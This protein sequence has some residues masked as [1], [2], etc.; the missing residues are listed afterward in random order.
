M[1]TKIDKNQITFI[2]S[3]F[4][5]NEAGQ[6]FPSVTTILEAYPKPYQLLQWL[7][8]VGT[9]ADDIRDAAGKRGSVVH[10]LTEEYDNG[11]EVALLD[12]TGKPA[13]SMSE[14]SMFE[15]YVE[16]TEKAN[17]VHSLIEQNFVDEAGGY[18]GTIDR[19]CEIDGKIILLDIKTS[20]GIYNSYWLQ[21]AAYREGI[22]KTAGIDV[23][24]VAIL[25]LNAKTR[26]AG[27]KG[28]IQG[29]G[30]QLL[31]KEDTT[32]DFQLFKS[33]Q[34]LWLAEHGNE[35]P[36]NYSYQLSHKK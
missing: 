6:H 17:P 30:W 8:E 10:S 14:W 33:V 4:Y 9:K 21:L 3:R 35:V 23:D 13:V 36:K 20:N 27:K 19:I 5:L 24:G 2:D 32:N 25:W 15:K 26:S 12:E 16:F 1:F 34:S 28:D 22:K 29:V 11:M 7:K 18:A 31:Q